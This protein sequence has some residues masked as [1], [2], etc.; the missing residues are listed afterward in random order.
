MLLCNRDSCM[1]LLNT[2]QHMAAA[3]FFTVALMHLLVWSR[4]PV[5]RPHLLFALTAIAAGGDA[6]AESWM[7]RAAT[8]ETMAWALKWYVAMS[9]FWILALFWFIADYTGV[10]KTG[11][12]LAIGLS[13]IYGLALMINCAAPH[14]FLYTQI[15]GLREIRLFWGEQINLADGRDSPWRLVFELSLIAM[16]ALIFEG[17]R[18]LC[19]QGQR[20]RAWWFGASVVIFMMFFGTHAML[21][22]TGQLDSPY[23]STYGFL[24]VV[25]VVSY[26]LAGDVVRASVLSREIVANEH[27]WRLLLENVRVLVAG[28]DRYGRVVYVNPYFEEVSGYLAGDIVGHPF[29]Q[30]LPDNL[31]ARFRKRFHELMSGTPHP[32]IESLLQTKDGRQRVILWANVAL[33]DNRDQG[34]GSLSIGTDIT[35]IRRK[36]ADLQAAVA[37]ERNRIASDLHDSVTQTL[38]S[39]AAIADALPEVWNRYPE[40]ARRALEDL[41]Q[42]TKGALAEMRTLLLELRPSALLEK[43]LGELLTQ[44]ADAAIGRTQMP[45]TVEITGDRRLADD[46]HIALYRV[47]QESLN[48]VIKHSQASRATLRLAGDADKMVLTIR[49]TVEDS[50]EASQRRA[51]LVWPSC[52]NALPRSMPASGS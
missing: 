52:A 13:V 32:E 40:E 20:L 25:L 42:L 26:D 36:E 46:V 35:E 21:V 11:R 29:E 47:A 50:T 31:R 41:R 43:T 51:G 6:I 4:Q 28:L 15:H 30:L 37:S 18:S 17:C 14:S 3:V 23:L 10:G 16:F 39:T 9:G 45:V 48:N 2:A 7:Y 12:R 8:V 33:L 38:F 5:S 49:I 34:P 19:R 1:D 24:V 44:L 27:R 22:D